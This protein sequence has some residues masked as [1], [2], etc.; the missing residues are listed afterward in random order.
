MQRQLQGH[1]V[2]TAAHDE[3]VKAFVPAPLPP[4]PPIEWSPALRDQ[5]DA[6]LLALGRFDGHICHVPDTSIFLYLYVRK[7]AVLSSM[8]EGT[9]SS[10]TDLL[11]FE[12][13]HKPASSMEDVQEVS[14]YVAALQHGMQRLSE[15]FPISLRLMREIHAV[16]MQKGRGSQQMPGEFRRS[17]NWIGGTRPG[18]AAFVPP[19]PQELMA[20]LG[21]LEKFLHDE[22]EKTPPLI[23]AAL[24]HVQFETIHPFLDGNGRLGRLLISLLLCQHKILTQPLL[25]LSLYFKQHRQYYYECL[26][27][28]RLKG[29]WEQWLAFF[30]EAVTNTANQASDT[31]QSLLRLKTEDREQIASLGKARFTAIQIHDLLLK[32]PIVTTDWL[33]TQLDIT[34]LTINLG[35]ENLITLGIVEE[36]TGQK[37]NRLYRY[38]AYMDILE[39][40]TE[41]PN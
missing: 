5:F 40:N 8:I 17:Q 34:P 39:E 30:A 26:N 28:V 29:D 27:A 3:Q 36:V 25:Y 37:R 19:P 31:V 12:Q 21:D 22:P 38:S 1:Y 20:C 15:G 10:L 35:L 4:N 11:K 32:H 24:S 33:V 7:E 6:A 23:K 18:N 13:G 16:L 2:T 41:L 9:Q 14:N